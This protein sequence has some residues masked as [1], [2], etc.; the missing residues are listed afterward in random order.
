[1][2]TNVRGDGAL[3]GLSIY[4]S[5]QGV[6]LCT[7]YIMAPEEWLDCG[8]TSLNENLTALHIIS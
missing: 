6:I 2:Y 8:G 1:M 7:L 3:L 4:L 5:G